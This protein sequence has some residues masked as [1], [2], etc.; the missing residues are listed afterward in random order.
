[1]QD[2]S[3][4]QEFLDTALNFFSEKG[5]D[6]TTV[7]DII[8][9]LDASKGAFY[10]Y[11]KSKE[12]VLEAVITRHIEAEIAI[13]Q[14]TVEDD[15]LNAVEKINKIL[16]DVLAHRAFKKDERRKISKMFDH[17]GNIKLRHKIMENKF[18]MLC[19]PYR[20]TIEQGI[21]EGV[22]HTIYPEEAAEQIINLVIILNKLIGKLV[23]EK[24]EKP[25][26]TAII[27]RKTEAY[28]EAVERILGTKK[29]S[30]KLYESV[31]GQDNKKDYR[32]D[33]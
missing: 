27:K 28:A 31:A 7:N 30:I 22:F 9:K 18:K 33:R 6:N 20:S 12:D 17:K 2:S 13:T 19:L 15:C 5:Y 11:F 3:R 24:G 16:N 21:R 32:G 23:S 25:D 26:N 14:K 1:M 29:G 8:G 10:H 4:K